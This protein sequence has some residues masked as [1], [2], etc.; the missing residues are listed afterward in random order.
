MSMM[1]LVRLYVEPSESLPPQH[2][3]DDYRPVIDLMPEHA[4][5]VRRSLRKRWLRRYF[6]PSLM[7]VTLDA[8]LSGATS[9]S[10]I[11]MTTAVAMPPTTL[12]F[13]G[14]VIGHFSLRKNATFR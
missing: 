11:D 10:Y 2:V 1:G 12:S 6:G 14:E 5:R 4:P 9:N 8:T 13:L 7:A 3:P